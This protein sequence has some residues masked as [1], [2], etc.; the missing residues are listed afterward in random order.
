MKKYIYVI[1]LTFS[2]VNCKSTDLSNVLIVNPMIGTGGDGRINPVAVVPFGMVQLGPD[3]RQSL[4]GYHYDDQV[5]IGFS[6]IHKSGAGCG[7]MLDLLFMPTVGKMDFYNGRQ[8][9]QSKGYESMFT[10]QN[11]NMI[12]GKY[13]VLL[14]NGVQVELS[15]TKRCGFHQY[16]FPKTDS[17]NVIIDLV[18]ANLGACSI[19]DDENYDNVISASLKIIDNNTVEGFR[20]STGQSEKQHVFFVA[21]FSEPFAEKMILDDLTPIENADSLSGLKIRSVFQFKSDG[22]NPLLVKVGISPISI[23]GARKNLHKEINH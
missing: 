5:I 4:N 23:E 12:P 3:T 8:S 22:K 21:E 15:A 6:H 1:L 17:A 18:H 20:I 7:D 14:D 13:S 11:E 19:Y 16:H 10:H 9:F 2:L